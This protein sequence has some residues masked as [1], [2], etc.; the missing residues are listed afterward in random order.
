MVNPLREKSI[1]TDED[2]LRQQQSD[3][4]ALLARAQAGESAA[5]AAL[6]DC[7]VNFVYRICRGLLH[8]AQDAED[9]TQETWRRAFAG[10]S[11]ASGA[12]FRAWLA[13][14]AT[15]IAIDYYRRQQRHREDVLTDEETFLDPAPRP[16]DWVLQKEA[17]AEA[18]AQLLPLLTLLNKG[19]R[20]ALVL[21]LVDE[22]GDDEIAHILGKP[23]ADAVA[24]QRYRGLKKI[25][26]W[27]HQMK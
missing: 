3:K 23:S 13:R 16:D 20:A 24:Q 9:A 6:Y 5:Q 19:Q 7:Y 10:L 4:A 18:Q 11:A 27:L 25:R 8:N 12:S 17:R 14:I 21:S 22:L 15:N 1:P 2:A 26:N